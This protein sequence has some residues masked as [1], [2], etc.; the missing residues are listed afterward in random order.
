MDVLS[1]YFDR[2]KEMHVFASECGLPSLHSPS[3][4]SWTVQPSFTHISRVYLCDMEYLQNF[5][6][7]G[8]GDKTEWWGANL[9]PSRT[10]G[11]ISRRW[12][13]PFASA[14][15]STDP[16][17]KPKSLNTNTLCL[18]KNWVVL[19]ELHFL[20]RFTV[21]HRWSFRSWLWTRVK[22]FLWG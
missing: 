14:V 3:P 1:V 18:K 13:W 7:L 10:H 22:V 6:G 5:V 15:I 21:A 19:Q 11:P 12:R 17:N 9:C 2:R 8:S 20:L 16:E 4:T